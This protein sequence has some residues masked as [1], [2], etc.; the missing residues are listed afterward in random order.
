MRESRTYGSVRG[1]LSNERPYRDSPRRPLPKHNEAS[2][3]LRKQS[4][5]RIRLQL[6]LIPLLPKPEVQR[7]GQNDYGSRLVGVS[8][9]HYLHA[10]R[11]FRPLY[12]QPLI[13]GVSN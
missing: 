8:M 4:S 1:A 13:F 3:R 12:K 10:R 7:A 11:K 5:S 9:G 2:L 6:A